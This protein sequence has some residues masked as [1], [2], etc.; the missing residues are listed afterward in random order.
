MFCMLRDIGH[1]RV[2]AETSP[3]SSAAASNNGG[4]QPATS[5]SAILQWASTQ[6]HSRDRDWRTPSTSTP[7]DASTGTLGS[8]AQF[9]TQLSIT[10]GNHRLKSYHMLNLPDFRLLTSQ[11]H[12]K[13]QVLGRSVGSCMDQR[14]KRISRSK[15]IFYVLSRHTVAGASADWYTLESPL[16]PHLYRVSSS[17]I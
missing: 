4:C 17:V 10:P 7:A 1:D 5:V 15:N 6:P 2:G 16:P 14:L 8:P 12:R 3:C 9:V 13:S 11:L